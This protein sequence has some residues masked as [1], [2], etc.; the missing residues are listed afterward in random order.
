[1]SECDQVDISNIKLSHQGVQG[2]MED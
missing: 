1:M 2:F